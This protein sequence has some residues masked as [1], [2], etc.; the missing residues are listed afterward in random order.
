MLDC[1]ME[2]GAIRNIYSEPLSPEL[3]DLTVKLEDKMQEYWSMAADGVPPQNI[4]YKKINIAQE[5]WDET[6]DDID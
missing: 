1:K 4:T 3:D 2:E 5:Q 6:D